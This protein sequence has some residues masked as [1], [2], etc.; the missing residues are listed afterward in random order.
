MPRR[1]LIVDP[2]LYDISKP[3]ANIEAIRRY[4]PQRFEMEQLTGVLFEDL[5]IKAMVGY[6][7]TSDRSFWVRGHMPD[8][9]LMPGVV[10]CEAA[11]QLTAYAALRFELVSGTLLGLAGLDSVRF[12]GSVRPGDTLVIQA[13]LICGNTKLVVG[14]FIELVGNEVICEGIIKGIPIPV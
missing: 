14:E 13:S 11:A 4:N 6:L 10:M 9:P 3:I 8:I 12:R 2:S 7:E 1:P 5:S